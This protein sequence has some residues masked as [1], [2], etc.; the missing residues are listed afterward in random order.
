MANIFKHKA[1]GKQSDASTANTL[2]AL[3]HGEHKDGALL[4]NN[5]SKH[6]HDASQTANK[7]DASKANTPMH[8]RSVT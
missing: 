1:N 8:R 5:N 7:N 3:T 2:D 6:P 4:N